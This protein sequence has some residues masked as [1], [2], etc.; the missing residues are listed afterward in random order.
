MKRNGF[1]TYLLGALTVGALAIASP[2]NSAATIAAISRGSITLHRGDT[3]G[4]HYSVQTDNVLAVVRKVIGPGDTASLILA[5]ACGT[6]KTYARLWKMRPATHDSIAVAGDSITVSVT[7]TTAQPC[8]QPTP[9]PTPTPRPDSV[10][11][12][13]R[14]GTYASGSYAI[15]GTT[16]LAGIAS[17]QF[18]VDGV[19]N[20]AESIAKYCL[21][22]GDSTCASGSLGSGAHTIQAKALNANGAVIGQSSVLSIVD[23]STPAPAP[24][25][26]PSPTPAPTG[27][28]PNEPAGFTRYASQPMDS[29]ANADY[30]PSDPNGGGRLSIIVDSTNPGSSKNVAQLLFP[31]GFGSGSAP[32][33]M[34]PRANPYTPQPRQLYVHFFVKLSANWYGNT[35][36]G[37]NKILFVTFGVG[38][39]DPSGSAVIEFLGMG[40]ID[41]T[42]Q[43][44]QPS[45]SP[46]GAISMNGQPGPSFSLGVNRVPYTFASQVSRGVWHRFEALITINTP[47]LEN[48]GVKWWWDGTLYGDYS[49]QI[50]W[51]GDGAALFQNVVWSPT[52]GGGAGQ[53]LTANQWMSLKDLFVSGK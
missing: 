21:F 27:T 10:S 36:A 43:A 34:Y 26:T 6:S 31:A 47:G 48:G 14:A 13:L 15:E 45:V 1:W 33:S 3:T 23:G 20:H 12:V 52:Y 38:G 5:K 9:T 41:G 49:N 11:L 37:V 51:S 19:L 2:G 39:N 44:L 30:Y 40:G 42:E 53:T 16:T 18:I 28:H 8:V 24:S 32:E 7:G 22:G 50:R 29:I 17:L 4:W 25:P 35:T 46:E